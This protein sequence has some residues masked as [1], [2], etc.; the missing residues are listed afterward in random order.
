MVTKKATKMEFLNNALMPLVATPKRSTKEEGTK[1][2]EN[3]P[4]PKGLTILSLKPAQDEIQRMIDYF[5]ADMEFQNVNVTPVIQ[6]RGRRSILGHMTSQ[7]IWKSSDGEKAYELSLAAECLARPGISIA[8]TVRHELIH[9]KNAEL[10]QLGI[11]KNNDTSN[12]GM[13]HNKTWLASA[14]KDGLQCVSCA[15]ELEAG[16]IATKEG[17]EAMQP[18]SMHTK[19]S[20][21]GITEF[22]IDYAVKV[23]KELQPNDD[24]FRIAREQLQNKPKPQKTKMRKWTCGCTN[25]RAAVPVDARCQAWQCKRKFRLDEDEE[26]G[27]E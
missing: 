9:L 23:E 5:K 20:G 24:A 16:T 22:T 14:E 10:K 2:T 12:N 7:P 21:H 15:L 27:E 13:Y 25:I 17:Q 8:Q 26:G 18:G 3:E 6:T 1:K 11:N 19:S 4:Q